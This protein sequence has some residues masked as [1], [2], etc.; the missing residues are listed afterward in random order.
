[1][2]CPY[3]FC[4]SPYSKVGAIHELP[5]QFLQKVY[6]ELGSYAREK[7]YCDLIEKNFLYETI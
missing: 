7:Q 6:N 4:K 1:M 3:S 5:L 2:N